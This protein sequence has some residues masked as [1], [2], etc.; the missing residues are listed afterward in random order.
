ML[1]I[2]RFIS[3][4]LD[5]YMH[6]TSL[7]SN[8]GNHKIRPNSIKLT[9]ITFHHFANFLFSKY[10]TLYV[11]YSSKLN[12]LWIGNLKLNKAGVNTVYTKWML[13]NIQQREYIMFKTKLAKNCCARKIKERYVK[14]K[15]TC[16][17]CKKYIFLLWYQWDDLFHIFIGTWKSDMCP[18]YKGFPTNVNHIFA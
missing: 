9:S 2:L 17:V 5:A 8:N 14:V 13:W 6:V 10:A 15:T 11:R 3:L 4:R 1:I 16:F 7:F 12:K 18:R